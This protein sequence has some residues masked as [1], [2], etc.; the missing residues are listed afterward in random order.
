M[1]VHCIIFECCL[2]VEQKDLQSGCKQ[3]VVL[4]DIQSPPPP[5]E[6]IGNSRRFGGLKSQIDKKERGNASD[7]LDMHG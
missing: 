4:E 7:L 5:L 6:E 2:V 3:C 1:Q